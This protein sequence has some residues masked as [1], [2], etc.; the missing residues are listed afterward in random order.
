MIADL[1]SVVL[2]HSDSFPDEPLQKKK[3]LR[4]GEQSPFTTAKMS[5]ATLFT[6][7]V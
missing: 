7:Q 3:R 1:V 2:I 6:C 4:P 5:N